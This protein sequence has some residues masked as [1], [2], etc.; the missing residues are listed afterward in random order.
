MYKLSEHYF[1]QNSLKF[2]D[3]MNLSIRM[4]IIYIVK[5]CHKIGVKFEEEFLAFL[6]KLVLEG[7]ASNCSTIKENR[8]LYYRKFLAFVVIVII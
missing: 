3:K 4:R 1:W 6:T 8:L 5:H 7:K 2:D